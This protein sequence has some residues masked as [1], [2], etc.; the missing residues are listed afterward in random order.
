MQTLT[1]SQF[2]IAFDHGA[3]QSVEIEP[4]GAR[5]AVKC[6]TQKGEAILVQARKSEPRLFGTVDSAL[7]LLHKLGVRRIVLDHLER[8]QPGQAEA[9]R[10]TRPDRA[11]ALTRAAEYDKWVRAKVQTSRDD[12]RPAITNED[13][14]R[15][16]AI[17]LAARNTN[18]VDTTST[19]V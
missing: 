16:R 8:W 5:F 14:Q 10:R 6:L 12:P 13:W 3:V 15:V 9:Q 11:E 17:K 4:S 1:Q 2:Q 19:P 7:K 18:T